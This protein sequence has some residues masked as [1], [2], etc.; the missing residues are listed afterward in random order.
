MNIKVHGTTMSP[1]VRRLITFLVEKDLAYELVNV[2]PLGEPDPDYLKISPLG[3]VPLLEVDGRYLPDSLSACT[4]LED[5]RPDPALLPSDP[6]NK[7]WMLWL[8]DYLGSGFFSR[9]E[10]PIFINRFINPNFLQQ[11]TD[12]DAVADALAQMPGFYDYLEQ[13]IGGREF[14]A[15]D[16]LTLTDLTAGSIF[17]NMR[18]GGEEVDSSRWPELA[19]YVTRMHARPSFQHILESERQALGTLSPVFAA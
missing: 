13:Q 18:H 15:S 12:H 16:T 14:L 3:K 7:A 1:W 4:Y 8:C 2:V 19:A 17:L 5:I 6:W 11:E 9:V 10:V